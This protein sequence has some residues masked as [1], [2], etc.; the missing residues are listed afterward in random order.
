MLWT[1]SL[2]FSSSSYVKALILNM[3]I[4]GGG[5]FERWGLKIRLS[6]C[7]RRHRKMF[8]ATLPL[9]LLPPRVRLTPT[10]SLSLCVSLFLQYIHQRAAM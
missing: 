8:S 7:K 9:H 10:L 5:A 4:V 3:M 1:E 2:F 6:P